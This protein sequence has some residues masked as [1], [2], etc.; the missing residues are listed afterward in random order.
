MKSVNCGLQTLKNNLLKKR[1][2]ISSIKHKHT[3]IN[4]TMKISRNFV[5]PYITMIFI[6]IGI[7]GILMALHIFDGYTETL[8]E[9]LGILF[10]I[11]SLLHIVVN[12]K[13]LKSHFKKKTFITS[14]IVVLLLSTVIAILGKGHGEHEPIIME[15]LSVADIANT[16]EI[17]GIDYHE[18]EIKLKNNDIIIDNSKTIEDIALKNSESKKKIIE[19]IVK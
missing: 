2:K 14:V 17:L 6:I 10:V 8:H 18:A 19:L 12:W 4:Y 15:K 7:T 1:Y 11:F 13:S 5:T 3:K 9:V 16:F